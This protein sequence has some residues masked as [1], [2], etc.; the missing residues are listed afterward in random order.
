M[1]PP[2]PEQ[3]PLY[4]L[5]YFR[6]TDFRHPSIPDA[7][8]AVAKLSRDRGWVGTCTDSL[9][10]FAAELERATVAIF[11]LTTGEVLDDSSRERFRRFVEDGGGFVGVHSATV[12]ELA[13]PWYGELV[14]AYFKGHPEGT[15]EGVIDV[16]DPTHPATRHLPRRWTV[17]EE[18]YSFE[19]QPTD[20]P[21][22]RV[23]LAVDEQSYAAPQELR[24]GT[25]PVAWY[26]EVGRGRSFQTALGH[27]CEAYR[28]PV[29]LEHVAGAVEW[30]ARRASPEAGGTTSR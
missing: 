1:L 29:F 16:V 30:A 18:W 19:R 3:E 23:V 4:A 2:M 11:L 9:E 14:G 24:M 17:R 5:A 26:R 12:T 7:V 21:G 25:H 8:S 6:A 28:D 27:A 20:V 13:W 22:T 10:T 15:P